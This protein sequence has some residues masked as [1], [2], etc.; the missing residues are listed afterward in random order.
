MSYSLA[1]AFS[2]TLRIASLFQVQLPDG[3]VQLVTYSV[4]DQAAGY[5]ADVSYSGEAIHVPA[6]AQEQVPLLLFFS[7]KLNFSF[8]P[9][10]RR[11]GG[12]LRPDR[13]SGRL[14]ARPS[15]V[16]RPTS[17]PQ[18]LVTRVPVTLA[19]LA[20]RPTTR[21]QTLVTRAPAAPARVQ[22]ASRAPKA[23]FVARTP[24]ASSSEEKINSDEG[25]SPPAQQL[26]QRPQ[27]SAAKTQ[28]V[29]RPTQSSLKTTVENKAVKPLRSRP[30]VP[31]ATKSRKTSRPR[32]VSTTPRL[33]E[34]P[35]TTT[36]PRA[37]KQL[38]ISAMRERKPASTTASP[39][40]PTYI[41]AS[42]PH[43]ARDSYKEKYH[44]SESRV[45]YS[46]FREDIKKAMKLP[47]KQGED[48]KEN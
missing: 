41:P 4:A 37:P 28:L 42:K 22:V 26:V 21:P 15:R 5:V 18:P 16:G 47:S 30:Q 35:R 45:L 6:L 32:V 19:T 10:E 14:V 7:K 25:R 48:E 43:H 34:R 33:V 36:S 1:R 46:L 29:P 39:P 13:L 20:R 2:Q 17:R 8:F 9:K 31:K 23:A 27:L 3:R 44:T 40:P 12:H 38:P 11:G 24:A